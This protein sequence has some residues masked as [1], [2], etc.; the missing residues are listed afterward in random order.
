MVR[1]FQFKNNYFSKE[2]YAITAEYNAIGYFDGL[3]MRRVESGS[4]KEQRIMSDPYYTLAEKDEKAFN[5]NCDY[6]NLL[7]ISMSDDDNGFWADQTMPLYFISF[8]R[9][10]KR[11]NNLSALVQNMMSEV[12]SEI[13]QNTA[14]S[15]GQNTDEKNISQPEAEMIGYYTFDSSDLII[16]LKTN[17]YHLGDGVISSYPEYVKK[18]CPTASLEKSFS[19]CVIKQDELDSSNALDNMIDER[20]SCLLRCMV[21]DRTKEEKYRK[22][23]KSELSFDYEEISAYDVLGSDDIVLFVKNVSIK[24][25]MRLYGKDGLLTHSNSHYKEA[26]FNVATEILVPRKEDAS[27]V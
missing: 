3:D 18:Y 5:E 9:F 23:L 2:K 11:L 10:Q 15:L 12:K 14:G 6:F 25:W 4:E 24:K 21:C 16:C 19:V 20:V 17:S 22:N 1:I 13:N 27:D 8:V 7:G 26:F